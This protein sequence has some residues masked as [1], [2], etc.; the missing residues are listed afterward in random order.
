MDG[1]ILAIESSG[2]G[3]GAAVLQAGEVLAEAQVSAPRTHGSELVPCI[4]RALFEARR[5]REEI[6]L[7]A[8]N[9]GPGSYTGLRIGLATAAAIG[10]ALGKPVAGVPC[11]ETMALQ[12]VLADAFDMNF[13]GELWPVLNARRGEVMTARFTF[14]GGEL[15]RRE[16]DRLYAP[17]AL[18][19][20]A[21]EGA[22][23]FGEGLEALGAVDFS[24]KKL[25]RGPL[26]F[27]LRPR[28]TALQAFRQLSNVASAADLP[29]EPVVPRYFRPILAKTI[30][31]R[32]REAKARARTEPA[33]EPLE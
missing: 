31:E 16:E 5:K 3:G 1:L 11:F 10:F 27:P 24:A 6:D 4:D 22:Q 20:A 28:S 23:V 7:V 32:A 9:C 30:A 17:Q 15:A 29:R 12:Y 18:V 33:V 13:R 19:E 21:A 14:A 25:V 26:S 8:V 2:E